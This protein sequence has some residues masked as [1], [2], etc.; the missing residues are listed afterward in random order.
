MDCGRRARPAA[1]KANGDRYG[2]RQGQRALV[3][4]H[5]L[6]FLEKRGRLNCAAI[7]CAPQVAAR[8]LSLGGGA[9][10]A[11]SAA[12]FARRAARAAISADLQSAETSAMRPL[13]HCITAPWP[14]VTSG[15]SRWISA[16]Q[17]WPGLGPGSV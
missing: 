12:L 15:Q 4:T 2:G 3:A 10:W 5:G 7:A 16:R 8:A 13:R 11:A 6:F 9:P 14:G 1:N 17:T